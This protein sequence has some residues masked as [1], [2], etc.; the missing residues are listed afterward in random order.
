MV[1][2]S[3]FGMLGETQKQFEP[4]RPV[5]TRRIQVNGM[6]GVYA[7]WHGNRVNHE[8]WFYKGR[9]V[10]ETF[11]F[12][13][14]HLM[15]SNELGQLLRP[16]SENGRAKWGELIGGADKNGSKLTW[17]PMFSTNGEYTVAMYNYNFNC[18]AIFTNQAWSIYNQKWGVVVTNKQVRPPSNPTTPRSPQTRPSEDKNDCLI[19]ATDAYARVKSSTY[20][21]RIAGFNTQ[22]GGH[23]VLLFQPTEGS[24]VWLYDAAGSRNLEVRSHD[25]NDLKMGIERWTKA[26]ISGLSWVED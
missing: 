25:L 16:Y 7:R 1:T 26:P 4:G 3:V 10:A 21:A 11:W 2:T 5:N 19:I 22:M 13:N 24:A 8:G 17:F 6:T 14:R 12:N 18:L 23:A 9:A 20:W 15:T